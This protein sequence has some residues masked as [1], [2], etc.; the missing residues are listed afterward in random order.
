MLST[1][2]RMDPRLRAVWTEKSRVLGT[3]SEVYLGASQALGEQVP[4]ALKIPPPSRAEPRAG[5][6]VAWSKGGMFLTL[7][8]SVSPFIHYMD[9][10]SEAQTFNKSPK[11]TV[12][13]RTGNWGFCPLNLVFFSLHLSTNPRVLQAVS[14]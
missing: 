4:V 13:C 6:L 1:L 3:W 10:E 8:Q 14:A 5:A 9:K 11:F 7:L 2:G 12:R